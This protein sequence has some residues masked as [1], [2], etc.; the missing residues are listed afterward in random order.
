MFFYV[1]LGAFAGVVVFG[2]L[3]IILGLKGGPWKLPGI[4][5]LACFAAL[6]ASAVFLNL[7]GEE[8]GGPG[9]ADQLSGAV[10]SE[11]VE[12]PGASDGAA[13]SDPSASESGGTSSWSDLGDID[14]DASIFNVTITVPADYVE[15]GTT[16]DSLNKAAK[17][18]GYK[19][20]TLNSDGSVTY[21]MTKSQHKKMMDGIAQGID[22]SLADMANSEEYPT[23]TKIEA[24]DDYTQFKVY[25]NT[26][27]VGVSESIATL[28]F[29]LFSG[30]YHVF[31]GT[32]PGG[33]IIQFINES[34]GEVIQTA[35][36]NDMQ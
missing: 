20:A 18:E 2:L 8:T 4:G 30:T 17:E 26:N 12:T 25:L 3:F 19:S 1:A 14:V 23:I 36:S 13:E 7:G 10:E 5:M 11:G 29:Y 34:T 24:N 22:E 9:T 28:G 16:Q 35:N 15:E 32:G 33:V 31:N 21:V 27:E 6:I